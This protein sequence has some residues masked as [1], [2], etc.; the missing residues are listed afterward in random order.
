MSH[1]LLLT[2]EEHSS[3][4]ARRAVAGPPSGCAFDRTGRATPKRDCCR[5]LHDCTVSNSWHCNN[6]QVMTPPFPQAKEL[7]F[8]YW[9]ANHALY[10]TSAS[11]FRCTFII[12]RI[13]LC[14][15]GICLYYVCFRKSDCVQNDVDNDVDIDVD[16]DVPL[17]TFLTKVST[18]FS[19]NRTAAFRLNWFPVFIRTRKKN[20][21]Y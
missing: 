9:L 3:L 21:N 15:I 11:K 2:A 13:R 14:L 16:I 17:T 12:R 19:G 20:R 10:Y 4:L 6:G 8:C 7:L 1:K 5:Q 18:R